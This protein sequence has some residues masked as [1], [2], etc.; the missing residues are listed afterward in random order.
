MASC[1]PIR[2]AWQRSAPD[3]DFG[4]EQT[5]LIAVRGDLA[6]VY[7]IEVFLDGLRRA[8]LVVYEELQ[9]GELVVIER[10]MVTAIRVVSDT[11]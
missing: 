5:H 8:V 9:R 2:E 6:H 10:S 1:A 3:A 4:I 7:A 11:F